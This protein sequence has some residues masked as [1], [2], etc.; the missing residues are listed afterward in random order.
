MGSDSEGL[1]TIEVDMTVIYA[2]K[3]AKR[4]YFLTTS[5]IVLKIT[6]HIKS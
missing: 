4:I 6:L 1:E 5:T 3:M 2:E